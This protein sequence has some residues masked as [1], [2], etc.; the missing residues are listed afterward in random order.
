MHSA[1]SHHA[2][3]VVMLLCEIQSLV[4][5]QSEHITGVHTSS[6]DCGVHEVGLRNSRQRAVAVT[7]LPLPCI[8]CHGQG[9]GLRRYERY[10]L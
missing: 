7:Q 9:T 5:L 10:E 2:L 3:C 6:H 8:K 1:T 4:E